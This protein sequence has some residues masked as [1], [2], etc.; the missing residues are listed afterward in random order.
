[1]PPRACH[2]CDECQG[3]GRYRAE[4]LGLGLR[5]PL[6]HVQ[7]LPVHGSIF[8]YQ[9]TGFKI[10]VVGS[11]ACRPGGIRLVYLVQTLLDTLFCFSLSQFSHL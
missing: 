8:C 2:F 4:G 7:L 11:R 1:M 6:L 10:M 3:E 9:I 5:L